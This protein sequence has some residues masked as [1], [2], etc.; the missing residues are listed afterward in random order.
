MLV[1]GHGGVVLFSRAKGFSCHADVYHGICGN[2][3]WVSTSQPDNPCVMQD[4]MMGAAY[5]SPEQNC[6]AC[7]KVRLQKNCSRAVRMYV[8]SNTLLFKRSLST[9]FIGTDEQRSVVPHSLNSRSM[10]DEQGKLRNP[11]PL[12][13]QLQDSFTS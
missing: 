4:V 1:A 12:M 7:G 5:N 8:M 10:Y 6:C 2:P 11:S 3:N 9:A 13:K